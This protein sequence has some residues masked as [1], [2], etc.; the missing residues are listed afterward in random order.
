[1]IQIG[2]VIRAWFKA[3]K[4][5]VAAAIAPAVSQLAHRLQDHQPLAWF[6]PG[7]N[8]FRPE[9]IST[10]KSE[11]E[12][13]QKKNID[14]LRVIECEPALTLVRDALDGYDVG[15]KPFSPPAWMMQ[16]HRTLAQLKIGFGQIAETEK[17][18]KS[19]ET[20][21]NWNRKYRSALVRSREAMFLAHAAIQARTPDA[22]EK[23]AL[24]NLV[25]EIDEMGLD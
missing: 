19:S 6:Q 3:T 16:L 15:D 12:D 23:V 25:R 11:I 1:M 14:L 13:L 20:V 7:P 5:E 2:E 8:P 22:D 24:Y 4:F 9:T 17:W 18:K 10:L 21:S